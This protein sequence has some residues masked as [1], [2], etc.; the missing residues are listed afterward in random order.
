M[1]TA[2]GLAQGQRIRGEALIKRALAILICATSPVLLNDAIH[3]AAQRDGWTMVGGVDEAFD[4]HGICAPKPERWLRTLKE[5]LAM[6]HDIRG[7]LH[8]NEAGHRATA[9]VIRAKLASVL[10]VG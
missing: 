7:T 3:A 1:D 9:A 2:Q 10:G 8:P 4:G 6:Q 5:S